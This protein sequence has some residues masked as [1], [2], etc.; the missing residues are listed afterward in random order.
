MKKAV[1]TRKDMAKA[2]V[3]QQRADIEGADDL[4]HVRRQRGLADHTT[5]DGHG[6]QAD[7]H[8]REEIARLRL[9]REHAVGILHA[10]LGHHLQADLAGGRNGNLGAGKKG[11]DHHQE[12]DQQQAGE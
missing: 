3:L 10:F 7:L 8:H 1:T 9:Q 6:I 4:A 12:Q 2:D 5:E 11:A